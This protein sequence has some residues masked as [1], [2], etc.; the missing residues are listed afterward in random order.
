MNLFDKLSNWT[1]YVSLK[2]ICGTVFDTIEE[3]IVESK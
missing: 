1:N 2:K 3:K